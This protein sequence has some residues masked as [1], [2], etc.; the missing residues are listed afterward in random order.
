MKSKILLFGLVISFLFSLNACK[1][2]ESAYK[3]AYEAAKERDMNET[4]ST[5]TTVEEVTPVQKAKPATT[6][7]AV[8]QKEK[9]TAVD[10]SDMKTF[11]VVVGSFMN[12]TNASSLKES[13]ESI[14]YK[15]FLAQNERGMFRVIVATFDSKPEAAEQRDQIKAR[16]YPDRFQDAWILEQTN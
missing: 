10:F 9:V 6:S 5:T 11:S 1:S 13:L 3:S 8:T 15:A 7:S 2:K 4:T 12:R 16:F 14:G